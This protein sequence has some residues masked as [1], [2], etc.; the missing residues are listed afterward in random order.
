MMSPV[1]FGQALNVQTTPQQQARYRQ[2]L[3]G[4]VDWALDVF[5]K[6]RDG[7]MD[8]TRQNYATPSKVLAALHVLT[9][10]FPNKGN[11]F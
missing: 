6:A 10:A 11:P 1:S 5:Q 7:E 8:E 3:E 4:N 9:N 2:L